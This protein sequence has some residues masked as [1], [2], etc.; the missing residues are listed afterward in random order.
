MIAACISKMGE[1]TFSDAYEEGKKISLDEAVT[2]AL[3]ES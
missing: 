3:G 2:Y 1:A